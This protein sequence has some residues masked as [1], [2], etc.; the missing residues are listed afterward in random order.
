MRCRKFG[1]W[2]RGD[3]WNGSWPAGVK[4]G[5][6]TIGRGKVW[7]MTQNWEMVGLWWR[8]DKRQ[9][10]NSEHPCGLNSVPR[11]AGATAASLPGTG[12]ST[13]AKNW[14]LFPLPHSAPMYEQSLWATVPATVCLLIR[15]GLWH[16]LSFQPTPSSCSFCFHGS[17][18]PLLLSYRRIT[19]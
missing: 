17:W 16:F 11:A 13:Q 3:T 18:N 5:E 15:R 12:A 2:G 7:V 10:K 14:S 8:W 1:G 9:G 6:G 19:T 4:A